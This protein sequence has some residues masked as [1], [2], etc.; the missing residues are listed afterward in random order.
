[1]QRTQKKAA[2]I[3]LGKGHNGALK[4][5]LFQLTDLAGPV[6]QMS[7]GEVVCGLLCTAAAAGKQCLESSFDPP[8]LDWARRAVSREQ[9]LAT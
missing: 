5:L 9:C 8:G 3:Q 6:Q 1:M 2:N 4:A 7:Q